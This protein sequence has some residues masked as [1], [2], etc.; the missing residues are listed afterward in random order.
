MARSS[1]SH[2]LGRADWALVGAV[3]LA[4]GPGL[5]A[6]ARV[7]SSTDYYTHGFLVPLVAFWLMQARLR[8][9]PAP[10]AYPGGLVGLALSG[11]LYGAGLLLGD[12]SLLGLA[13]VAA[14]ASLVV[15]F[16]G[17]AGLARLAFPVGFLGFMVPIPAVVLTPF[18]GGLQLAVSTVAVDLLQA[19]GFSVV[20]EGN[21]VLLPE[22][23]R[24]FVDEACSGITSLVTLLPLGA[25]LAYFTQSTAWRRAGLLVA[26]VPIAMLGNLI[27][28]LATVAAADRFGVVKATS[29]AI[30][31]SA[32]ML[33]FAL[34]C[35]LLIG[36]G[37]LFR[38][39]SPTSP[40][41]SS[42]A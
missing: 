10:A 27:R 33:T 22:G 32:G 29:G 1:R 36:F 25:I 17:T 11:L 5:L 18:I 37:A 7:W 35:G 42:A 34:A 16:W 30:H 40:A 24:L 2:P 6:L 19:L 12:P 3:G 8:G 23:G 39:V 41:P 9:L 31:E 38:K 4:F 21:V 28:V 15:R 13:V 26:V 20:Q 14:V